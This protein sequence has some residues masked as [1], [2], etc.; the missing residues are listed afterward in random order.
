MQ[1]LSPG[2]IFTGVTA[3]TAAGTAIAAFINSNRKLVKKIDRLVDV[4][5][6]FPPHVHTNGN[7]T[8]PQKFPPPTTEHLKAYAAKVGSEG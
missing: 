1:A 3:L 8:Y 4:M 6:Y 5:T 7:I 2:D